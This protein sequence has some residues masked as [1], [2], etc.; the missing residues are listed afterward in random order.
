MGKKQRE[1]CLE[2]PKLKQGEQTFEFD[3]ENDFWETFHG[4]LITRGVVHF[5][6]VVTKY[7]NH[8]S[9]QYD[10]SGKVELPCDRCMQPFEAPVS[11]SQQVIY[12][13][14]KNIHQEYSDFISISRSQVFLD[15][16]QE[17]YDF[18]CVSL[19][20]RRIPPDC[21]GKRCPEDVL[22]ILKIN[23]EEVFSEAEPPIDPRWEALNKLKLTLKQ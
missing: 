13:Y 12:G 6:V 18:V 21:P 9:V 4:G 22:K 19:P 5:R 23:H 1:Y 8:L 16:S 11:C 15:I 3:L 10:A 7:T 14:E 17:L 20:I 2:L